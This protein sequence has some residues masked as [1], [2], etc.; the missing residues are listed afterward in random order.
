MPLGWSKRWHQEHPQPRKC[1]EY[2][3]NFLAQFKKP[4]H[5]FPVALDLK[6]ICKPVTLAKYNPCSQEALTSRTN[7]IYFWQTKYLRKLSQMS[8]TLHHAT[9]KLPQL[10][11]SVIHVQRGREHTSERR[12]HLCIPKVKWKA[13]SK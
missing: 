6:K 9:S 7:S 13:R 5:K 2:K 12:L 3:A 10:Y 4:V 11:Q 1:L 8:Q